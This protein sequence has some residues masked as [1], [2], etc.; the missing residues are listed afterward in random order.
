MSDP[1]T[2]ALPDVRVTFFFKLCKTALAAIVI[3][4]VLLMGL[5][6]AYTTYG[7]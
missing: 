2:T 3:F 7:V 6:V 4:N 5:E 1:H